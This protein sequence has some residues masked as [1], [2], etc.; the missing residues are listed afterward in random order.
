ME[1]SRNGWYD[2]ALSPAPLVALSEKNILLLLRFSLDDTSVAVVASTLQALRAFL[3]TEADEICLDR[4]VGWHYSDGKIVEPELLP[5][6]SDVGEPAD[7]KDHELAQ[8]DTV[9]AAMRSDIVLRIR[10]RKLH[11]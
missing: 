2:K 9:A 1:K 6:K 3:Y 8:F 11:L 4:L 10:Y 7:L 5:P